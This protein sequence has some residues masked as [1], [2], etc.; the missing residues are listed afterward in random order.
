MNFSIFYDEIL[1]TF[2]S[3][4]ILSSR[5]G[6]NIEASKAYW[7]KDTDLIN[8]VS[9]NKLSKIVR[10]E[11]CAFVYTD[12]IKLNDSNKSNY[13]EK[14]VQNRI[15][16]FDLINKITA[17]FSEKQSEE[18]LIKLYRYIHK[19]HIIQQTS[20]AP[21]FILENGQAK[22]KLDKNNNLQIFLPDINSNKSSS[23]HS[24]FNNQINLLKK[25]GFKLPNEFDELFNKTLPHYKR[26]EFYSKRKLNLDFKKIFNC[27]NNVDSN[28]KI[29]LENELKSLNFIKTD[30]NDKILFR[31]EETHIRSEQ[32]SHYFN[33]NLKKKIK[34][35]DINYYEKLINKDL[36]NHLAVFLNNIGVN[37]TPMIF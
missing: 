25:L 11:N 16:G 27:W 35:A 10:K 4:R 12:I 6:D 36:K 19:K 13:I 32:L 14:I 37:E 8:L 31:A 29:I 20:K 1:D 26:N 5:S 23:I 2:K 33:E 15:S 9:D 18:W 28:K 34:Y 24:R 3:N 7:S 17:V 22:S 21:I 30:S